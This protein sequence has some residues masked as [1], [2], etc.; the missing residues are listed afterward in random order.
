MPTPPEL[1]SFID[2]SAPA[3]IARLGEA[4]AIPSISGEPLR[5]PVVIEMADHKVVCDAVVQAIGPLVDAPHRRHGATALAGVARGCHWTM[6]GR[7]ARVG[8]MEMRRTSGVSTTQMCKAIIGN[9]VGYGKAT[10]GASGGL[11][12][13]PLWLRGRGGVGT[14]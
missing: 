10:K 14:R 2:A 1:L 11:E 12:D 7:R 5:R 8:G 6:L 3:F 4:V 13:P 9:P